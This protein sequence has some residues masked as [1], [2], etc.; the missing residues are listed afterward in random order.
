MLF[1]ISRYIS[2]TSLCVTIEA[3]LMENDD[4]K[5]AARRLL[6]FFL[7]LE[8]GLDL[9]KKINALEREVF[10]KDETI[11]DLNVKNSEMK[12][13]IRTLLN[14]NAFMHKV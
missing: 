4:V 9:I 13:R 3:T 5:V 11:S 8:L 1:K 10:F 12:Q 7:I 2:E 14:E 6:K